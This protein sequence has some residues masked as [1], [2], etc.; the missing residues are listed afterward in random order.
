MANKLKRKII[1]YTYIFKINI[2]TTT[3]MIIIIFI[4]GSY[5]QKTFLCFMVLAAIDNN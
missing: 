4:I 3:I 2:T 1:I 5:G